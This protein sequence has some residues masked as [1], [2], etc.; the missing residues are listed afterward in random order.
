M[1]QDE[2]KLILDKH[3][4]WL[5]DEEGG[6]RA[7]LRGADLRYADLR[8]TDLRGA[9]LCDA[10]LRGADLRGANLCD[11]DLC[12]ADLD[13]SCWPIWC[14]S[15]GVHIDERIALQLL[16]HT[17]YNIAYSKYISAEIKR[18]LLTPEIVEIANRSHVV[19]EHGKPKIEP[20]K[21]E[22]A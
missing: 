7:N 1:T 5:N 13:Y 8:D 15:L 10:V 4:K 3:K 19:H 20:Y 6:E 12:D 2:I 11:A 9:V 17:L 16:Y 22:Q 14:G 21:E 18:V